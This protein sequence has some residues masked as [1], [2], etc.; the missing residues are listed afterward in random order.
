MDLRDYL[1]VLR[2]RYKTVLA[3]TLIGILTAAL[4]ASILPRSYEARAQVFVS[5]QGQST[6]QMLQGSSFSQQRVKSYAETLLTPLV[7]DPV[8]ED[9]GLSTTAKELAEKH[10]TATVPLDTVLIDLTVEDDDP[11][12]AAD[13]ANAVVDEFA[14]VVPGL[15]GPVS[16]SSSPVQVTVLQRGIPSDDPASPQVRMLLAA[17]ALVGLLGGLALVLLREMTDTKLRGEG[18]VKATTDEIVIGGIGY[19]KAVAGKPVVVRDDPLSR[20]AES[21]RTLRT[22]LQFVNAAHPA[23]AI[24]FTSSV[25]GEGKTTTTVNLALALGESG[26]QVCLVEADLRRPRVTSYL[27]LVDGVGLTNLIMGDADYD[28]VL[29]PFGSTN[30]SVIGAGPI[31]PN[32]S[33]LLGSPAMG[34]IIDQLTEAFD[35]VLFDA[36]PLLPVTDAAVLGKRVG[37]VAVVVGMGIAR[38]E[39]LTKTLELLGN[40]GADVLGLVLNRLPDKG[41]DAYAYYHEGYEADPV[42]D[43]NAPRTTAKGRQFT[44]K[45]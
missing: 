41:A 33:E 20:R 14:R 12:R 32:P 25:P 21:Y 16:D 38:K 44:R 35:Y 45:R 39:Q 3:A 30:V 17:G 31:P 24:V 18:D 40:V 10:L 43:P 19:S 2:R 7:L 27:R 5:V 26:A 23:R 15:E 8:V 42:H 4:V 22:N 11:Q 6:D 34:D 36:P 1:R 37:G 28:D 9:L 29:Q 13:I